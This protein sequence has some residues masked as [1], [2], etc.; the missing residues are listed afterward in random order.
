MIISISGLSGSGKNT[1]GK[2]LSEKLG[3]RLVS[4]TFK[5]LAEKEGIS[6]IEFQKK[7]EKDPDIDRKFD[8]YLKEEAEKGDC[9]FTTW[10]SPWIVDADLRVNV[11]AP[12]E[13]RAERLAERDGISVEEAKKHIKERDDENRERWKKLYKVDIYDTSIFDVCLS[14]ARFKPDE[15]AE[16]VENISKKVK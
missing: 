4:P 13:V 3:L 1:L 9:I 11:F 10:L 2:E 14:S 7:A 6:L 16:I 5:D 12:F 15:L 8:E